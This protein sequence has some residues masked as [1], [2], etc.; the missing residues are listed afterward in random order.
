M[1]DTGWLVNLADSTTFKIRED[2]TS[3]SWVTLNRSS[4]GAAVQ[5]VC[6]PPA[7]AISTW[8]STTPPG[9]PSTTSGQSATKSTAGSK[10]CWPNWPTRSPAGAGKPLMPVAVQNPTRIRTRHPS[11]PWR[12][13]ACATLQTTR[14]RSRLRP[15]RHRRPTVPGHGSPAHMPWHPPTSSRR[16]NLQ[17][18]VWIVG[19]G[20]PPCPQGTALPPFSAFLDRSGTDR[21]VEG[22]DM[23]IRLAETRLHHGTRVYP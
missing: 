12:S 22:D 4:R 5:R 7:S 2:A 20:P 23:T 10:P 1:P 13:P 21:Y 17:C 14:Q 15:T 18:P 6:L 8:T 19:G 3:H 9:C 11:S 16:C